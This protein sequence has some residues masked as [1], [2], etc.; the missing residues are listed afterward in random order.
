MGEGKDPCKGNLQ[1]WF[2]HQAEVAWIH[3]KP[4]EDLAEVAD[5][6]VIRS[7]QQRTN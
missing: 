2:R 6:V 5:T 4:E 3:L 7:C 1:P